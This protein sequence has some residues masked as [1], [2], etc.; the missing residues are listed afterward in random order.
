[1]RT[2]YPLG[3]GEDCGVIL[4]YPISTNNTYYCEAACTVKL[5]YTPVTPQQAALRRRAELSCA[6]NVKT[7]RLNTNSRSRKWGSIASVINV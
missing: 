3:S 4:G 1:M 5:E 7:W 2:W 6:V